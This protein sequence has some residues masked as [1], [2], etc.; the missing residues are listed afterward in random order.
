MAQQF[1]IFILHYKYITTLLIGD[2]YSINIFIDVD[3]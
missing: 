1:I 2:I 3:I